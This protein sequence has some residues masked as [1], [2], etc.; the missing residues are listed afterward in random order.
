MRVCFAVVRAFEV[1]AHVFGLF[2]DEQGFLLPGPNTRKGRNPLQKKRL[3]AGA[4]Q[5]KKYFRH[6][7]VAIERVAKRDQ[8]SVVFR[9]YWYA[10]TLGSFSGC[11][12]IGIADDTQ[13]ERVR[14]GL[15]FWY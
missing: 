1:V 2:A 15:L 8:E 11:D 4:K 12:C 10:S 3:K 7:L 14:P 13:I 5:F 6:H 9:Y